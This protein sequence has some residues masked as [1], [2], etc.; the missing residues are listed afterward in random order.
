MMFKDEDEAFDAYLE[1]VQSEMP[2]DISECNMDFS[3]GFYD[4]LDSYDHTIDNDD[5]FEGKTKC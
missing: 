2:F 1:H 5:T 3:D 4:W